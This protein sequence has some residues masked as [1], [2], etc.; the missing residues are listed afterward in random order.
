M[1]RKHGKFAILAGAIAT[2][3]PLTGSAQ[4]FFREYGTSRSSGGIGPVVA[5]DYSYQDVSPSDLAPI[6]P[7]HLTEGR[8]EPNFKI[9]DVR[10][11]MAVGVGV[12]FN[13]NVNLSQYHRQSDI[14]IRPSISLDAYMRLSDRNI[15]RFSL[16]VGYARY[17][18]HTEYNTD[19]V[20]ISPSTALEYTLG[21]GPKVL[22]SLRER[23]AYQ[24]DIFDIPVLSNAAKYARYE[25]QVGLQLQ[26][27]PNTQIRAAVGYDHY[28]LWTK[29]EIFNTQDRTIDTVFFKPS[30]EIVSTVRLGLNASYSFISFDS[31]ERHDGDSLL[32]GPFVQW[33]IS[34]DI[35]LFAEVGF[36][37]ISFDGDYTPTTLINEFT[38]DRNFT[39]EQEAFVRRAGTDTDTS[40]DSYYIRL[41]LNHAPNAGDRFRERLSGSKTLEVG[42]FT[43]YYDIYHVEYAFDWKLFANKKTEISPTVFY[44]Y[45]ETSGG[46]AEEAHRVGAALG[47]RQYLT[48]S[49]TLGLDY[50]F[51]YKDSNFDGFDYYQNLGFVSVYYKF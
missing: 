26:W 51:I 1:T 33:K 42:F 37:S 39:A 47:I 2:L 41:E 48:N 25:N 5:S 50:R 8:A 34:Q 12:E 4:E 49:I 30:Y 18:D 23:F 13:D 45:Y 44:E 11:T 27:D 38:K 35:D 28:N 21:L 22:L 29:E 14:I 6:D 10:F 43:N 19:G 32:V 7:D 16:G 9:G 40:N 15:L 20:L 24:E 17:L 31:D 36:Q 46:V 3:I